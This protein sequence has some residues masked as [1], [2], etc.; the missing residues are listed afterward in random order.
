MIEPSFG[1]GRIIYCL[2]EHSFWCRP[3]DTARA[4]LS[5]KPLVAPTKVLLVPLS[6]NAKL[7]PVVKEVEQQLKQVQIPFKVDDSSASIGK[8]YARNDELG[9]PFGI[10]IDFD[11][12][13]D[14]SVTLR[15]RDS[16]KQVRGS[17]KEIIG[18]IRNI[19][20]FGEKWDE[21]VK[22]LKEFEG[23]SED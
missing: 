5:F 15:E 17:I 14:Q 11:S 22:N 7:Q 23:Q 16:T 4:V 1:I 10:T 13:K 20:Y 2:Y 12:L 6:N 19:T 8:R 18:A 21:G 3:E 9:T